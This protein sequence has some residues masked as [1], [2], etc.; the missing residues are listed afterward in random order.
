MKLYTTCSSCYKN[1]KLKQKATTK[2]EFQRN[3]GEEIELNCNH[4][5][6]S[7]TKHVNRIFAKSEWFWVLI[8]FGISVLLSILLFFIIGGIGIVFISVPVLIT[9]GQQKSINA[10]NRSM[11]PRRQK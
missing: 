8:S 3:F 2:F 9:F 4:C 7:N 1:I 11:I 5:G 6:T 10:F